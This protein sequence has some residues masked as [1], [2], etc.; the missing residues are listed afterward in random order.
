MLKTDYAIYLG[1]ETEKISDEFIMQ[2]RF[3]LS[4]SGLKENKEAIVSTLK[5]I[6][7]T[8]A[9]DPPQTL[10]Q[11][12]ELIDNNLES[13]DTTCAA[14]FF[15]DGVMYL[16]TRG[17][18]VILLKRG[19]QIKQIISQ[20]SSASGEV[21]DGDFYIFTNSSLEENIDQEALLLSLDNPSP[22]ASV[23]MLA[24]ELKKNDDAGIIAILVTV[25]AEKE[26]NAIVSEEASDESGVYEESQS[27]LSKD[28][29]S[30]LTNRLKPLNEGNK[31]LTGGILVILVVVLLYSVV[32]GVERRRH[33]K[34]QEEVD[35][36]IV[37]IENKLEEAEGLF[38]LNT[39]KSLS[40][41]EEA[42]ASVEELKKKTEGEDIK[43]VDEI[44]HKVESKASEIKREKEVKAEEFFDLDLVKK[45][46]TASEIYKE[47]DEMVMLSKKDSAI[48]SL[49]IEKKATDTV[50][51]STIKNASH[52]VLSQG[53]IFYINTKD[54]IYKI[55]DGKGSLM[56]KAGSDDHFKTAID[57]AMY[58][59]N[60]YLLDQGGAINKYTGAEDGFSSPSAYLKSSD[61]DLS[62]AKQLSIDSSVYV[63]SSSGVSRFTSGLNDGF[64]LASP[65]PSV[66]FEFLF[67]DADVESLYLIDK[68]SGRLFIF[69]KEGEYE[70][71]LS[72]GILKKTVDFVVSSEKGVLILTGDKIYSLSLS[73]DREIE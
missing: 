33:D 54:G 3:F 49:S 38:G 59:G 46:A 36:Q 58:N 26:I 10:E 32:F 1:K 69:N 53:D 22:K 65:E 9:Q 66:E 16:L 29:F 7:E 62:G 71:Q 12:I 60:I 31:M 5:S 28:T 34:L 50:A 8:L 27:K 42:K 48:Y 72:S 40:L 11:C 51:G 67:T 18:G 63:L 4:I 14:G 45:G 52:A 37:A 44:A 25:N 13:L 61:A 73:G 64:T 30:S 43:G 39:D 41:L 15:V 6:K 17:S 21:K 19:D 68:D 2:D 70:R 57:M 56:R 23:E 47:Q 24:A 35:T 20:D 55:E